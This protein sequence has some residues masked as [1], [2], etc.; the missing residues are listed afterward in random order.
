MS[1]SNL[2]R[3]AILAGASSVPIA[4][5]TCTAAAL[6]EI[7]EDHPD[8]ELLGLAREALALCARYDDANAKHDAIHSKYHLRRPERPIALRWHPSD[9]VGFEIEKLENG[10]RRLWCDGSDIIAH[11]DKPVMLR[12][13]LGTGE[14]WNAL[15]D[16][17]HAETAGGGCSKK[18]PEALKHLLLESPIERG[19]Q[20]LDEIVAAF[21]RHETH[22][23]AFRDEMGLDT[24][25]AYADEL[26]NQLRDIE[27]RIE[28]TRATTLDG[29]RAKAKVIAH[30]CQIGKIDPSFDYHAGLMA[31]IIS[32]LTGLPDEA[33]VELLS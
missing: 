10:R 16:A 28:T 6:A 24:A 20:R 5:F 17:A 15:P 12:E 25:E 9:P 2:N 19:Q 31:S 14:Q 8:A 4:S 7:A 11:R 26:F 3:R 27:D 1:S 32:D 29:L 30:V 22:L 13:W 33:P 23:K 18:V 21:D